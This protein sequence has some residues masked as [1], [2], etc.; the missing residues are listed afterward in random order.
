MADLRYRSDIDGLRAL[1]VAIVILFHLEFSWVPGGFVGVDVF[2]VISGF[3][4]TS[5]IARQITQDRFSLIDFYERRFRRIYPNLLIV[6]AV[7]TILGF[8]AMVPL[9][10]RPFG[11]S[12]IWAPLSASNFAF[13]GGDGYFDPDNL[14]KPLLHTWSLG[15]EEQFY[16]FFPWLL[17][18][19]AK[20]GYRATWLIA[21][22]VALSLALSVGAAFTNWAPSYFLLPTR[23]WELG[24][25]A[26]IAILPASDH[27]SSPQ[28]SVLGLAGLLA[29]AWAALRLSES[30]PFPGYIALAPTL[31]AAATIW[32]NGG[33]AGKLLSFRPFVWIGRLSFALYLWHWPLISIAAGIG[34]PPTDTGTRLVIAAVMLAL[35]VV[36]YFLWEQPIRQRRMLAGRKVF[37]ATLTT[38]VV[39]LVGIGALIFEMRGVPQRLPKE[40]V[41]VDEATRQ[42]SF[43][44]AKR[45]PAITK[46]EPTPCP[47]GDE[48][49]SGISFVIIGDSHAQAVAAEIG[50]LARTYHL[51]GL[52]LGR[53]GCPPLAGLTRTP[54]SSCPQQHEFAISQIRKYNPKLVILISQWTAV[55]GDPNGGYKTPLFSNGSPLAESDRLS[56]VAS[57]LN[58]TLIAIGNRQIVTAL[59]VPE[60]NGKAPVVWTQWIERLGVPSSATN[61]TLVEYWK[62]QT[63][64]KTLLDEA[65]SQ[66][67]NLEIVSPTPLFC[68]TETCVR[69]NGNE[70][71]YRD[72]SHL[73][74][75]GAQLYATLFGPFFD[76]ISRER[77]FPRE[78]K[79]SVTGLNQSG[80]ARATPEAESPTLAARRARR[81]TR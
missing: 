52:Y 51:R 23:F 12:L 59:T 9:T 21:G 69:A 6:L 30:D 11:R 18:F 37:F 61:L 50:D 7:T 39:V 58:E 2:F 79:H 66:H 80:E 54:K 43:L 71:L 67:S 26:L 16:L 68:S 60:Y 63:Y 47:L 10:Y 35:S 41:A 3:L 14:T 44:I 62:R 17:I 49:A 48:T 19:A 65:Q 70:I 57:A 72:N 77:R 40:L 13:I 31:G 45:C 28:R 76:K 36:G 33:L 8:L 42:D 20:R 75:A 81:L 27:L 34:L 32:A 46:G 29:I 5:L 15:V 4:I 64:V 1:A 22:V 25:G 74:H 53:A 24:I 56:S 55:I 78:D 38:F 73:S